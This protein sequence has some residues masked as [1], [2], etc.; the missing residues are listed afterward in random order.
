MSGEPLRLHIGGEEVKPGWKILN[1]QP[2][3]GVDYVGTATDLSAIPDSAADAVYASH[4]YEHLDYQ[5][6][7]MKALQEAY[8]V[9]KPGGEIMIAVPD[10]RALCQL[11]LH[12]E[13]TAEQRFFVMRVIYGGQTNPWDY[14][15]IG[16]DMDFLGEYLHAVGFRDIQ[17]VTDF[18]VF[19][20]TS[21]LAFGAVP[22]SL[23]A[24][25]VKPR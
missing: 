22:I 8:R 1:I 23:N 3:P 5:T 20:D 6:E 15:K 17:R 19:K 7:I 13:L 11:F 14:H 25:A 12:P 24:R 10:L 2:G 9:L 21:A 18:G 16:F 4:I